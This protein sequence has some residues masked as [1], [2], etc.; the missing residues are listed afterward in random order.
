MAGRSLG[1]TLLSDMK[2]FL[3]GLRLHLFPD[4]FGLHWRVH[5]FSLIHFLMLQLRCKIQDPA[6]RAQQ[7]FSEQRL[8]QFLE[9][10]IEEDVGL[11]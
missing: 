4:K 1:R 9:L 6:A 5:L 2:V 11:F 7:K 8:K 3:Y 10:P